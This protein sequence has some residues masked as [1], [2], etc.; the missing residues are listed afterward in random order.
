MSG[1]H[2][3]DDAAGAAAQGGRPADHV[4]EAARTLPV[5]GEFDVVVCGGG[6]AGVA[7]A[8]CAA[9][10]GASVILLERY[11][12]LGGLATGGLV[13]TVPPLDNGF[14]G[15]V[16]RR[17]EAARTYQECANSGDDPSVDGLI[18]VDPEI[19]K[20]ELLTLLLDSGARL[21]LHTAVV[22]SLTDDD[23]RVTGVIVESKAGRSAI[24]AGV[25]VDTTGDGDLAA[26]AGAAFETD[27]RPLPVTLMSTVVGVDTERA[28]A[29]LG[30]WG[31]LRALVEAAV[32][33]G[34][35]EFDLEVHSK[36][37]AP[38][39]FA[40]ELC[41]PGQINLWSGSM[42]GVDGID[43]ED[44]TRAEIVTRQH[45]MRLV[46]FLRER[47]DG[48]QKARLECTAAQVG[49][50]G[51]RRITGLASPTLAQVL[52]TTFPDTVAK[53]YVRRN[54]RIPYRSLVPRDVDGLLFAGRCLSAEADA[55]V[56]LR[57]IPVC[58]ATGQA[59]G[60][61][62]ALAVRGG[63]SPRDLDVG[64]VQGELVRQGMELVLPG[65]LAGGLAPEVVG[66]RG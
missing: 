11:G 56:Q 21:L 37:W 17:L 45:T 9:R 3:Y 32:T 35:L 30:N 53:P 22:G 12:Y 5:Y 2:A 46:A 27:R 55:M 16:R 10:C 44:L 41:Y 62:A 42:F 26:V 43:P 36:E 29:Q 57:L 38:G 58:F 49:V 39:V 63:L 8:A 47:L 65:E 51:T 23:G 40:A 48:F 59:A 50:R 19:L 13:I 61:A 31:R 18:A 60:T 25:V 14:N 6:V 20:F 33:A 15:E 34:E 64:L 66:E 52:S 4:T 54:M 7:A 24:R 28:L 1:R